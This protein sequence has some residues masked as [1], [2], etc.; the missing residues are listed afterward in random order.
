MI[1]FGDDVSYVIKVQRFSIGIVI[2]KV[3]VVD[4]DVG[5]DVFE[6][7]FFQ[8]IFQSSFGFGCV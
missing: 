5:L 7:D 3:D 8:I 2:I 4:Q 1:L 6:I